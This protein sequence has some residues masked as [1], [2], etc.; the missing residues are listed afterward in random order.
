MAENIKQYVIDASV[1]LAFLLPDELHRDKARRLFLEDLE[2]KLKLIAPFLLYYETVNGLR[3]AILQ[4]R[5]SSQT[6]KQLLRE[7]TKLKIPMLRRRDVLTEVL[8]LALDYNISAYDS[9]Y[10]SLA[11]DEKSQVVTTDKKLFNRIKEKFSAILLLADL[12][13]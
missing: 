8:Q 4:K 9:V 12:K 6:G 13:V 10:I 5:I 3:T 1:V 11:K 2:G 7:F